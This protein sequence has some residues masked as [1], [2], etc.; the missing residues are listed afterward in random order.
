MTNSEFNI[1][2]IDL[3][4]K[5]GAYGENYV[6]EKKYSVKACEYPINNLILASALYTT[7]CRLSIDD[8]TEESYCLDSDEICLIA[9]KVRSLLV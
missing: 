3:L 6:T 8:A 1:I 4:C 5:L 2:K 9:T 7:I